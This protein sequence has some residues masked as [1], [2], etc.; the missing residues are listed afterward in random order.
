MLAQKQKAPTVNLEFHPVD[1]SSIFTTVSCPLPQKTPLPRVVFEPTVTFRIPHYASKVR[2]EKCIAFLRG[3]KKDEEEGEI[4][5]LREN[6]GIFRV[7]LCS[8]SASI[9]V[10]GYLE[11]IMFHAIR[12]I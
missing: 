7:L 1:V 3:G 4:A 6:M 9:R 12:K 8:N 2:A 11:K 10:R 5:F